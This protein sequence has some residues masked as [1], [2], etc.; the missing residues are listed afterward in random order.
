MCAG[1]IEILKST[2]MTLVLLSLAIFLSYVLGVCMFF[3]CIPYSISE[4]FYLLEDVKK[5]L[6]YL[7]S[8]FCW[9]ITF[10]LLPPLI[11]R[12]DDS[13]QWVAFLACAGLGFVGA[14]PFFKEFTEKK[15]HYIGAFTCIIFSQSLAIYNNWMI[16]LIC[17]L[18]YLIATIFYMV[19]FGH[20]KFIPN[21]LSSRPMFWIEIVAFTSFYG[22]ILIGGGVS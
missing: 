14:A 12:T 1:Y 19:N 22:S 18:A 17:W 7:F 13:M 2:G 6:G 21:Y 5:N 15:V 4:T 11:E 3:K 8:L 20:G 9:G 16:P 10:T